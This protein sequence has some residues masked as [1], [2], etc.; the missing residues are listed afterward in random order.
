MVWI[1]LNPKYEKPS[2]TKIPL[3]LEGLVVNSEIA[4]Y[5]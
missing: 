4:V 1:I 2:H 5:K 3:L